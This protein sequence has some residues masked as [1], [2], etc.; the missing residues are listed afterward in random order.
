MRFWLFCISVFCYGYSFAQGTYF[1]TGKVLLNRLNINEADQSC[2]VGIADVSNGNYWELFQLDKD[3]QQVKS[4]IL[5]LNGSVFVVLGIHRISSQRYLIYCNNGLVLVDNNFTFIKSIALPLDYSYD[6]NGLIFHANS[7][8]IYFTG[9]KRDSSV[10]MAYDSSLNVLKYQSYGTPSGYNVVSTKLGLSRNANLLLA[11]TYESKDYFTAKLMITELSEQFTVKAQKTYRCSVSATEG[12]EF[13]YIDSSLVVVYLKSRSTFAT[14]YL[15]N[16]L[17]LKTSLNSVH[18]NKTIKGIYHEGEEIIL[19]YVENSNTGILRMRNNVVENELV[20]SKNRWKGTG[21]NIIKID[22]HFVVAGLTGISK[23]YSIFQNDSFKNEC[24]VPYSSGY[25]NSMSWESPNFLVTGDTLLLL[26]SK[27]GPRFSVPVNIVSSKSSNCATKKAGCVIEKLWFHSINSSGELKDSIPVIYSCPSDPNVFK[28]KIGVN[29]EVSDN[30]NTIYFAIDTNGVFYRNYSSAWFS[31]L[32]WQYNYGEINYNFYY[33]L[34]SETRITFRFLYFDNFLSPVNSVKS[35]SYYLRKGILPKPLNLTGIY[36]CQHGPPESD[37]L[38]INW[39]QNSFYDKCRIYKNNVFVEELNY[40]IYQYTI[41]TKNY[42]NNKLKLEF[43][44]TGCSTTSYEYQ[45]TSPGIVYSA[46][47]IIKYRDT[48]Y[49]NEL[50]KI[51]TKNVTYYFNRNDSFIFNSVIPKMR[52]AGDATYYVQG[53][54]S[55]GCFSGKSKALQIASV[56]TPVI[57]KNKPVIYQNM[58]GKLIIS[59]PEYH[60]HALYLLNGTLIGSYTGNVEYQLP[61]GI[62]LI[63]YKDQTGR[64][65]YEKIYLQ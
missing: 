10:L 6:Q 2:F 27:P 32:S 53:K 55:T 36:W 26:S 60:I 54:D 61:Q 56:R 22:S 52:Y 34:K 64:I 30:L 65:F 7:G 46:S 59:N 45:G 19:A 50:P 39:P 41:N 17:E 44:K 37:S 35:F 11:S 1:D 48:L 13:H 51:Y 16:N 47:E 49:T 40:P 57:G 24:Y 63:A 20:S 12:P 3:L 4:R 14:Y 9:N 31:G 23:S 43:L 25:K 15:N 42:F 58:D 38:Q 8:K 28:L 33:N 18:L 62:Y 21:A 29:Y 5:T